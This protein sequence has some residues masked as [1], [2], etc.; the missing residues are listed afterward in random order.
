MPSK[1]CSLIIFAIL[2]IF[3][4]SSNCL[5][6]VLKKEAVEFEARSLMNRMEITRDVSYKLK[7]RLNAALKD[8]PLSEIIAKKGVGAV[9]TYA[10]GEGGVFVKYM[11][12]DGLISFSQGRQAAPG[13]SLSSR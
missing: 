13:V 9:F 10:C 8:G 11:S 7:N 4:I 12:G 1:K 2:T 3:F 6:A 5:A